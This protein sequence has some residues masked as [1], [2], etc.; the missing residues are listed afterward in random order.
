[1]DPSLLRGMCDRLAHR[2]P[3]SY[4]CF[5]EPPVAL[6]HRR[7]SIIDLS[8]GDQPLGNEDGSVQVIFNGE[9]Y[10]YKELRQELRGKG[11]QFRTESDTEVLAHLYEEVGER[12]PEFLNGMFA[13]AIWDARRERL[14]LARDRLGKKP[15]YYT[16]AVKGFAL[17]FA[18]E[19]K[20][21][22][23]IPGFDARVNHRAVA[24]FLSLSY[25]PDPDTIYE[26]TSKLAPASA[27]VATRSGVRV[28]RYWQL[29]LNADRGR[30]LEG[31]MEEIRAL[32]K[33]AVRRRLLSD[34]PLGAFLSGGV[35]SS[36]VVGLMA[37]QNPDPVKTFSIGFTDKRFDELE[38]ARMSAAMHATDHREQVV[39][40]RIEDVFDVLVE[41]FDEPF[42]DSSAIPMLYVS[43]MAR[44]QVTV[45]LCGDGADEIFGGYRRYL[46]GV[47]EER[48]RRR[49]PKWFRQSAIQA[50]GRYYPKFDYL[51]QVFRAKTL[52]TNVADD[53]G[54]A[55]FT[56]MSAFRDAGLEAV[57]SSHVRR[58]L[59]G[60]SPRE[61]FRGMF[62][63]VK[64]YSPLEQMQWVDLQ[65]YLPGDILV[66]ADRATM[67]YSLESRSP[68]LDYRM[69]ELA[70]GLPSDFKLHGRTGKYIFKRAVAPYVP[71]AVIDRKKMGFSVPLAE[72][73][74][75]ALKPIFRAL[76]FKPEM[77]E[78]VAS[79]EVESI[80]EGH[81]SRLHNYDRKLWSLLMLA[82]WSQRH[83][84]GRVK[85]EVASV[86][87][88]AAS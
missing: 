56:T 79:R 58:N 81:Q 80:W 59:N 51:P 40:P 57:L 88:S 76:V 47:I 15:L 36:A 19:L 68:W 14:M 38:Y 63:D 87:Q 22:T 31:S 17:C 9:I 74:R 23:V 84:S 1:M 82:A 26:S 28:W 67:A 71:K 72:W 4:G 62:K 25:V 45:A 2:G 69:A 30:S 52:L 21:L 73:F 10:N 3:D 34:V 60:Y 64:E 16:T 70:F 12:V 53:L 61:R 78:F 66:K 43:R 48:L 5:A 77:E 8:T 29:R 27:L 50:A 7:L 75:S 20:A 18:S 85:D 55:Y 86:M 39:S 35:D 24:D 13:F 41:H 46:H 42:A 54:N 83:R 44:E 33:D 37:E 11:H 32:A 49:F 6:G 65:T